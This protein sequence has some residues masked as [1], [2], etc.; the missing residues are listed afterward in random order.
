LPSSSSYAI[1]SSI[2]WTMFWFTGGSGFAS[3]SGQIAPL[4]PVSGIDQRLHVTT[5]WCS[6]SWTSCRERTNIFSVDFSVHT[7]FPTGTKI[8]M[9]SNAGRHFTL[10]LAVRNHR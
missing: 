8:C 4:A 9:L 5:A 10:D 7:H 2:P 3:Y 1:F 6:F